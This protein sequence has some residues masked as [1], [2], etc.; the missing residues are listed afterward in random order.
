[1]A[2]FDDVVLAALP[3]LATEQIPLTRG[4]SWWW[5]YELRDNNGDLVD[6]ATGYTITA[7]IATAAG[8]VVTSPVISFPAT[9]VIRCTVDP[10]VATTIQAGTYYHEIS[11]VRDSDSAQVIVVGAGDATIT[12]RKRVA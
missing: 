4:T 3:Y 6:L 12:V 1:M 5:E 7:V 8:Q 10:D 2:G 11:I 9:G